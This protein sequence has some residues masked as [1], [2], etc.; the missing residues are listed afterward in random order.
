MPSGI[1]EDRN[2][3]DRMGLAHDPGFH[4]L[5]ADSYFRLVG[6]PL[7]VDAVHDHSPASWLYESAAFGL[8]AHG[9]GTDPKFIYANRTAQRFFGYDWDAFTQLPSRLSATPSRQ[10]ERDRL[11]AAVAAK[12]FATDYRGLRVGNDGRRFWIEGVTVWELLDSV[13]RRHGQAA[14]I[15]RIS[16]NLD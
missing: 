16:H 7:P 12:G 15:R 3:G 14:L 6:D 8:L 11:L 13:G 10:D 1:D 4:A 9:P 2:L 5:L